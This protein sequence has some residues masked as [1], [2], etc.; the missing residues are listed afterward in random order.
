MSLIHRL[1]FIAP[2]SIS[3]TGLKVNITERTVCERVWAAAAPVAV[4]GD[5]NLQCR[6]CSLDVLPGEFYV[7]VRGP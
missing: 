1:F 2:T 4:I 7:S 5:S 3:E 6:D